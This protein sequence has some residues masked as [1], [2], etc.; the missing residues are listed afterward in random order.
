MPMRAS[1]FIFEAKL[2]GT[3]YLGS[4]RTYVQKALEF[5]NG[6]EANQGI[7]ISLKGTNID[8]TLYPDADSVKNL[9]KEW[10]ALDKIALDQPDPFKHMK[11]IWKIPLQGI[12]KDIVKDADGNEKTVEKTVKV[13]FGNVYKD[14]KFKITKDWNTGNV[15]EGFFSAAIYL[16]LQKATDI[17][18][19]DLINFVKNLGASGKTIPDR[20][21]AS[22]QWSNEP[23]DNLFLRITLSAGNMAALKD[24]DVHI[25]FNKHLQGIVDYVND[26]EIERVQ[27]WFAENGIVDE[28]IVKGLGPEDE[29]GS[30]VDIAITYHNDN[31]TDPDQ[32]VAYYERSVKTRGGIQFGQQATGGASYD[33]RAYH[34]GEDAPPS[35][36][37]GR[38][39]EDIIQRR[40]EKQLNYWNSLG[41][42]IS[43]V[44]NDFI[45]SWN[46]A[47]DNKGKDWPN[48]FEISYNEALAGFNNLKR[49]RNSYAKFFKGIQFHA[50]QDN[51]DALVT[52][53]DEDTGYYEELDFTRLDKF[54]DDISDEKVDLPIADLKAT[55]ALKNPNKKEL[56]ANPEFKG[57]DMKWPTIRI[58]AGSAGEA[59]IIN[60]KGKSDTIKWKANEVLLQL[61]LYVSSTK[62]TNLLEKGDLLKKWTLVASNAPNNE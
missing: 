18:K 9:E 14:A 52:D 61:R 4:L 30:K 35:K 47:W 5:L 11:Q 2:S 15:T 42:D 55:F 46:T 26:V 43:T 19:V 36:E 54:L 21:S 44:E 10:K 56:K 25:L 59:N 58:T 29:K 8:Y 41:I 24:P 3:S 50:M 60:S 20:N 27:K 49:S 13:T 37:Q 51:P 22:T 57:K 38:E 23:Q 28:I 40:W 39:K 62:V 53:F 31:M 32:H 33:S 1:E 45:E 34:T 17:T 48:T 6:P 16:R 7:D 12:V